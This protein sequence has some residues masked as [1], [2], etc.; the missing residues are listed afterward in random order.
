MMLNHYIIGTAAIAIYLT[1]YC[2]IK[3]HEW[4]YTHIHIWRVVIILLVIG[5]ALIA[6][7]PFIPLGFLNKGEA[8]AYTFTF[9]K[10]FEIMRQMYGLFLAFFMPVSVFFILRSKNELHKFVLFLCTGV[11]IIVIAQLPYVVKFFVLGRQF[12]HIVL[13]IG[14]FHVVQY[15][16]RFTRQ[17]AYIALCSTIICIYA[18]NATY[19]KSNLRYHEYYAHISPYELDAATF[20]KNNYSRTSTLLISDPATQHIL[21]PFSQ[22][23]TQG[24]AYMSLAT[25]QLLHDVGVKSEQSDIPSILVDLQKIKDPLEP[26]PHKRLFVVSGRYFLWQ[27]SKLD[28]K[29]ALSYNIWY[30]VDF[31]SQNKRF[32]LLL[33]RY[34]L[35]F[36]KV[37]ENQAVAIFELNP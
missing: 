27:Y 20:L 33:E 14:I 1:T 34:P 11:L 15:M 2:Y 13:A 22:V 37:F 19:W 21:E 5:A 17:F 35:F 8:E 32:L 12:I 28:D 16:P 25:R 23:N 36:T 18:L 30:P 10:K 9:S 31:T 3:Y 26:S 29:E 24:G 4:L 6:L 7:S